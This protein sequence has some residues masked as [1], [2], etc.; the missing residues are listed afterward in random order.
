LI[1]P[2]RHAFMQTE[3]ADLAWRRTG[4][5]IAGRQGLQREHLAPGA[6]P[7]RDAVGDRLRQQPP[8]RLTVEG[9]LG[10]AGVLGIAFRLRRCE[11]PDCPA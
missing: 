2:R 3:A 8:H 6:R 7:Q 9:E 11:P 5:F 10:K 1:G 4:S